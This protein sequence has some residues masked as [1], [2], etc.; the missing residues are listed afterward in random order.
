[1][2]MVHFTP[3]SSAA[4]TRTTLLTGPL[5][6]GTNSRS[7]FKPGGG[8]SRRFGSYSIV[9]DDAYYNNEV[10]RENTGTF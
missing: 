8:S 5:K 6:I 9:L 10:A 1:M 3:W 4:A 7:Y 2:R